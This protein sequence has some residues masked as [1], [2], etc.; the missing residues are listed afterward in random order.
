MDSDQRIVTLS[1]AAQEMWG[2]GPE[3]R[4]EPSSVLLDSPR[5]QAFLA[6]SRTTDGN[7]VVHAKRKDGARF[8]AS[9]VE[10]VV[11]AGTVWV[12]RDAT[13]DYQEQE[14]LR[15]IARQ[16]EIL[17][18]DLE[19]MSKLSI[20]DV[21]S[22][23]RTILLCLDTDIPDEEKFA[24]TRLLAMGA[25]EALDG[26]HRYLSTG[27]PRERVPVDL[28]KIIEDALEV[29]APEREAVQG[30]CT[31]RD[32]PSANGDPAGLRTLFTEL[33]RNAWQHGAKHVDIEGFAKGGATHV[34]ILDDGPGIGPAEAERY[35][36]PRGRGPNSAGAG[37]G[38]SLARRIA[39][40]HGGAITLD[41]GA[42]GT[43]LTITLDAP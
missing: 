1:D 30:T 16:N 3:I 29:T 14:R 41:I 38:L 18:Q 5:A 17:L 22:S 43:Q 9:L 32:V 20:H 4:G 11:E 40:F 33:L 24:A 8:H 15:R 6:R 28:N 42:Q 12:V 13:Q 37:F 34:R 25:D 27:I 21:R 10:L 36:A 2:W 23:L 7:H 19:T 26:A 39:L 35:F 31:V